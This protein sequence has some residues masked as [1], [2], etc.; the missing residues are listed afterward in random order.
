MNVSEKIEF[1]AALWV[2]RLERGLTAAEQDEFLDWLGADPRHGEALSQQKAGWTRLNL[3]ADWRPM[4]AARPNRDLLAPLPAGSIFRVNWRV[5][6][7]VPASLAAAAAVALGVL[8]SRPEKLREAPLV[9]IA[10]ERIALI[11]RR[12]LEDGSIIELNRGAELFVSYTTSERRVRL[13]RGEA[14]FQVAKDPGRPFTV[15]AGEVTV[16]AVGTAFNVQRWTATV[17]VLVTEGAVD[18]RAAETENSGDRPATA[19]AQ[20]K[21]G[22]RCV[23]SLTRRSPPAIAAVTRE[24]VANLLAW[25]P[26]VLDFTEAPLATIIAEFNRRNA[27]FQITVA[28]PGLAETILSASLRSD[29]V[30]GFLRLLEGGFGIQAEHSGNVVTLR[31]AL[32]E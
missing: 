12:T 22:H 9:R 11:E 26:Q 20:V 6:W 17:E 31:R 32:R 10:P 3:L 7:I 2:V 13:A 16:R 23:V 1:E 15:S 14:H 29:N 5:A 25:Q 30:E 18:V 4:H 24:E 27:P 8:L 21:A 28:D 19:T